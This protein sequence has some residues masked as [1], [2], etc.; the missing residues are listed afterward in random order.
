MALA[1]HH[2]VVVL[3]LLVVASAVAQLDE[4]CVA[5]QINGFTANDFF[6]TPNDVTLSTCPD[7]TGNSCC[8]AAYD[9]SIA[10]G[11]DTIGLVFRQTITD[12]TVS[13][14]CRYALEAISCIMCSPEQT[15]YV[16]KN[17]A[18]DAVLFVCEDLCDTAY[19]ACGGAYTSYGGSMQTVSVAFSGGLD[20]CQS[21]FESSDSLDVY[22]SSF[23]DNCWDNFPEC[24]LDDYYMTFTDCMDGT[25]DRLWNKKEDSQCSGGVQQPPN[26]YG[27]E[28]AVSC[29]PGYAVI[30]ENGEA[31]CHECL[32]GSYSLGGGVRQ[33]VWEE[34][35]LLHFSFST[36][37]TIKNSHGVTHLHR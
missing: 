29:N 33:T 10:E 14:G 8:S 15:Y 37:C 23:S 30:S 25:R 16:Q 35:N 5:G 12:Q 3:L 13:A 17:K 11:Q 34:W 31:I 20:F 26:E 18:N 2:Y 9:A 36:Y 22:V 32:A 19:A 21:V 24:G 28:C 7:S 4:Y 1:R 6:A 27:L